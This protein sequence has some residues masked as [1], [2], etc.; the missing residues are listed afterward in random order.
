MTD[1]LKIKV[2]YEDTDAGGVVYHANYLR[3]FERARTEFLA[4]GGVSIAELHRR[5]RFFTVVHVDIK[6]RRPAFLGDVLEVTTEMEE[7]RQ[8]SMTAR[9]QVIK[10]GTVIAEAHV[11]VACVNEDGRPQR[12]PEEMRKLALEGLGP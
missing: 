1:S 9:Q 10:D 2:Y 5:G 6:Y 8:A 11:T 3:Y 12:L 7:V 4:K